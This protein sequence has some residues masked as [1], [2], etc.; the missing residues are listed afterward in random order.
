MVIRRISLMYLILK[1][2]K[3]VWKKIRK[4]FALKYFSYEVFLFPPKHKKIFTVVPT[5][6]VDV[7]RVLPYLYPRCAWCIHE[8][9]W[10]EEFEPS[11]LDVFKYPL[12][13][14]LCVGLGGKNG[15]LKNIFGCV[16]LELTHVV[17]TSKGNCDVDRVIDM[18]LKKAIKKCMI[19]WTW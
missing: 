11:V 18:I 13:W 9:S 15:D 4:Y 6:L 5:F 7:V 3:R 12:G 19:I 10:E 1:L 14:A 8:L 17:H 16:L 2:I